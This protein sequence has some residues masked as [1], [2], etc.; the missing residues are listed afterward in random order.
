MDQANLDV[1]LYTETLSWKDLWSEMLNLVMSYVYPWR[2][3]L[4][5]EPNGLE[6]IEYPDKH[7]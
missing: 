5:D 6:G 2:L 7:L 1:P 3:E 4:N